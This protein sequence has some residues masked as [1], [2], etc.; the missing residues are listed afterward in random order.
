M[1]LRVASNQM[2]YSVKYDCMDNSLSL[3]FKLIINEPR[4]WRLTLT[5]YVY[6]ILQYIFI[7]VHPML[8]QRDLSSYHYCLLMIKFT[9][10]QREENTNTQAHIQVLVKWQTTPKCTIQ[11]I[12]V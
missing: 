9:L 6:A 2:L 10:E 7:F 8:V 1:Y 5:I 11:T 12:F 3:E 4:L